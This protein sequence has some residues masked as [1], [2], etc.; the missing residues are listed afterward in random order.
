MIRVRDLLSLVLICL[1]WFVIFCELSPSSYL[2]RRGHTPSTVFPSTDDVQEMAILSHLVYKFRGQT[3]CDSASGGD[4]ILPPDV[5]CHFYRHDLT[6]GTQVLVLSNP[7]KQYIAVVFAGTDD[8]RTTLAD[9]DILMKPFGSNDTGLLPGRVHAGFD[10]NVFKHG[11]DSTILDILLQET[12]PNYRTFT[13]GHS[14]GAAD[15]VLVAADIVLKQN[16]KVT[17]INFG[18][19]R[20]GNYELIQAMNRLE[21]LQVWRFVLGWDLVPRLPAYP[22]QH[23]G[24][25][26]QMTRNE[27]K[28]Y[29]QHL[30]NETLGYVGVPSGW[31][32][33]PFVWVPG[34][35]ASH[36]M[37]KYLEHLQDPTTNL[38]LKRF[39]TVDDAPIIDDDD[40]NINPPDDF[41]VMNGKDMALLQQQG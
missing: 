22:F 18:C 3:D 26:V 30:G 39:E 31:A 34:A 23:I 14:L 33:T 41:I 29:Y 12:Q 19:P 21:Q 10:N 36:R 17:S 27:T 37:V 35:M 25:T 5:K 7:D 2:R 40:F 38:D 13:T 6:M 15:A 28:V 8:L 24:H 11:L 1:G 16:Q 4:P 9:G 32:S 20:I